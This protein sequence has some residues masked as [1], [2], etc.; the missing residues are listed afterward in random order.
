MKIGL[1][2]FWL[3]KSIETFLGFLD[4]ETL[5]EEIARVDTMTEAEI[6]EMAS[7]ITNALER[8]EQDDNRC[9]KSNSNYY[10]RKGRDIHIRT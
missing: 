4:E 10:P 3:K 2:R 6:D 1:K 9:G 7:A 8:G 5:A